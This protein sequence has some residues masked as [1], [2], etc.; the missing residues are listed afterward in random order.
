MVIRYVCAC[1]CVYLCVHVCMRVRVCVCVC[2]YL[3]VC[4]MYLCVFVLVCMCAYVG[5]CVPHCVSVCARVSVYAFVCA[6]VCMCVC[7]CVCVWRSMRALC[8]SMWVRMM[9]LVIVY[10]FF[11]LL[12]FLFAAMHT[13]THTYT[14]ASF[15]HDILQTHSIIHIFISNLQLPAKGIGSSSRDMRRKCKKKYILIN[16]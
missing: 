16:I 3:C 5:V 13:N 10:R 14:C 15:K 8:E 1:V 9:V 2:R 4:C 11:S 12:P 6:C 7:E